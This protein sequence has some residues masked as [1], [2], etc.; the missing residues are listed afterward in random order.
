[1][2]KKFDV[3]VVGELLVDFTM[4]GQSG[5]GTG[6]LRLVPVVPPAMS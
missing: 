1:M 4:A 5:K 3:I 2:D 6:C